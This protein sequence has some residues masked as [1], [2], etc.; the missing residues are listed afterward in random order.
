MVCLQADLEEIHKIQKMLYNDSRRSVA[1]I[2]ADYPADFGITAL[3]VEPMT[4]KEGDK[5]FSAYRLA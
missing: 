5:Y 3:A 1:F 4:R 2:D